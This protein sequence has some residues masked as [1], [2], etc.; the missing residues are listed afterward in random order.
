[1]SLCF[2]R[3]AFDCGVTLTHAN[4]WNISVNSSTNPSQ[5]L[6]NHFEDAE[7][8]FR[9]MA[10]HSPAHARSRANFIKRASQRPKFCTEA[11][12]SVLK[13]AHTIGSCRSS[14]EARFQRSPWF[15]RQAIAASLESHILSDSSCFKDLIIRR[16]AYIS[17]R[18]AA[19]DPRLL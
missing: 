13:P 8:L 16:L 10:P 1:M 2:A 11:R 12:N 14:P 15:S 9:H 17:C 4:Y 6:F 18:S 3:C 7:P 5:S 19:A